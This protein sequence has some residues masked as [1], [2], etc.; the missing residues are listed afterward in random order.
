MTFSDGTPAMWS[1]DHGKGKVYLCAFG[2]GYTYREAHDVALA[3][4]V[5]KLL[6]TAGVEAYKNGD[7]ERGVYLRVTESNKFVNTFVFNCSDQPYIAELS[8]VPIASSRGVGIS[9]TT[10]TVPPKT[11]GY[12]VTAK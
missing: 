2:L 5:L 11:N 10:V 7:F 1:V 6:S 9:G 8:T 4:E 3:S 12:Y